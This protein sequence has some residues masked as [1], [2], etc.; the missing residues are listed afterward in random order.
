MSRQGEWLHF[1]RKCSAVQGCR[2]MRSRTGIIA[3]AL[4]LCFAS[5][6]CLL[7]D[8]SIP[9]E[10]DLAN[11]GAAIAANPSAFGLGVSPAYFLFLS[12]NPNDGDAN[13]FIEWSSDGLIRLQTWNGNPHN[14]V[15]A[16]VANG[17]IFALDGQTN[18]TIWISRDEG[19]TWQSWVAPVPADG[20][21]QRIVA[22]NGTVIATYSAIAFDASSVPKGYYSTDQQ[23]FNSF[24]VPSGATSSPGVNGLDCSDSYAYMTVQAGDRLF[25]ASLSNP[26]S[27][28]R[29]AITGASYPGN[30]ADPVASP[31]G[32]VV[33]GQ[34]T[35]TYL[36]YSTDQ[37]ATMGTAGSFPFSVSRTSGGTDY[38]KGSYY[39]GFVD[40]SAT[41]KCQ[42]FATATGSDDPSSEITPITFNCTSSTDVRIPA[43]YADDEVV[44]VAYDYNSQASTG[45]YVSSDG[46]S[47]S[48][49][50]L[51]SV[52][53]AS[54]YIS[55]IVRI[56]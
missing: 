20:S 55:S 22:C 45:L 14:I 36:E 8:E 27:W 7:L 51:S 19:Q 17:V 33:F 10:G 18:D 50:D 11:L 3:I 1:L 35:T 28:S 30:H 6:R 4:M 16:A 12:D 56:R 9:S 15:R 38:G 2:I 5:N 13:A 23:A 37:G 47:F 49:V 26:S 53:S 39:L 42:I 29:P 24:F 48:S 52:W 54:G 21:F 34:I 46:A 31:S 44:L 43:I 25:Q 32:L 40:S 41:N